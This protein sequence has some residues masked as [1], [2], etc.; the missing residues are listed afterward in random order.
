MS[1]TKDQMTGRDTI[2]D[3]L[4]WYAAGTLSRKDSERVEQAVTSNPE[5]A[6]RLQLVN[7]EFAETILLNESL[8]AP[9]KRAMEKLFSA[10]DAEP[11]RDKAV[12]FDFGGR[13]AS[14]FTGFAPRTL[15]YAGTAAALAL[16]LQAAVIGTVL[17]KQNGYFVASADGPVVDEGSR[18]M[19]RFNPQA[20][21]ADIT[22]FLADKK[23]VIVGGPRPAGA[24]TA[25]LYI[26]RVAVTG[27]PKEQLAKVLKDM[28]DGKIVTFAV[29]TP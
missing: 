27:L 20:T 28:Q 8:G 1:A 16:V 23:M 17:V 14:F 13:V 21:N 26:V 7:D 10:I 4:P 22:K 25:D 5:L 11:V 18:A 12:S 29:P 6:R 3:L 2:E 19:V 9:S 24:A 15:A